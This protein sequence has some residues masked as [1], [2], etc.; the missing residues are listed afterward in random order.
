MKPEFKGIGTDRYYEFPA[1][2]NLCLFV[3][4]LQFT[5]TIVDTFSNAENFILISKQHEVNG[6]EV[7]NKTI[8]EN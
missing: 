5:L 3:T 7:M 1:G 8:S 4:F 6:K 2:H